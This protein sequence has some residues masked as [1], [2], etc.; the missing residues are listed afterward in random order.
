MSSSADV[1]MPRQAALSIQSPSRTSRWRLPP[2]TSASSLGPPGACRGQRQAGHVSPSGMQSTESALLRSEETVWI[3]LALELGQERGLPSERALPGSVF[4]KHCVCS[5]AGTKGPLARR[6]RLRTRLVG[7]PC[8][9]A[10][11]LSRLTRTPLNAWASDLPTATDD[12][13]LG[14][15]QAPRSRRTSWYRQ[16]HVV[17]GSTAP[18]SPAALVSEG[19][20]GGQK[21]LGSCRITRFLSSWLLRGS[22]GC[23]PRWWSHTIGAASWIDPGH[24]LL[25][26]GVVTKEPFG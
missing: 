20:S 26:R 23:W 24:R 15:R 25:C 9:I 12:R 11:L 14:R 16:R 7:T 3:D 19:L 17:L 6:H 18:V 8:R 2:G 21:P 10:T 13:G 22:L 4:G 5:S 1:T